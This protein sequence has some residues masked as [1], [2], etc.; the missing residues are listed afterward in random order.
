MRYFYSRHFPLSLPSALSPLLRPKQFSLQQHA[1]FSSASAPASLIKVL[2]ERTSAPISECKAALEAE[3]LDIE[4]ALV[5]LRK[6]GLAAAAKKSGRI[7]AE[8]LVGV[9]AEG[10]RGAV[11]ATHRSCTE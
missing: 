5:W 8:G 2:R 1:C 7:A 11:G 3:G 4:K 9:V 10:N 6:K